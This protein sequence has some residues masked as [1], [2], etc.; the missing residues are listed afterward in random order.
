[1]KGIG[2]V[3]RKNTRNKHVRDKFVD[4]ANLGG[5]TTHDKGNQRLFAAGACV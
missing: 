4:A 3:G 2:F 5:S 1:M